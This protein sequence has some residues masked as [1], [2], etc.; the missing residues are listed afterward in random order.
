MEFSPD[1][2]SLVSVSADGTGR[3]WPVGRII[4]EAKDRIT[5][6]GWWKTDLEFSPDGRRLVACTRPHMAPVGGTAAT[7]MN[8]WEVSTG[9]S[10]TV[11]ERGTYGR[12]DLATVPGTD[13]LLCGGPESLAVK[14]KRTGE[15]IRLLDNDPTHEYQH[16]AVSPDGK[17]AAGCGRLLERSRP[18]E[19]FTVKRTGKWFLAVFNL[20]DLDKAKFFPLPADIDTWAINSLVFSLDGQFLVTGGGDGSALYR[21][22]IFEMIDGKFEQ[23]E[24]RELPWVRNG[25]VQDVAFSAD[26]RLVGV[27]AQ[28][29]YGQIWSLR[30]PKTAATFYRK[31]GLWA[32][33]FSPDGRILALGDS[34]GLQLCDLESQ[35]PLATIPIGSGGVNSLRFSPDGRTL[36]WG[37]FD[38][39]V[40]FLRTMPLK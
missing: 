29:G 31:N 8:E 24:K 35:F 20:E 19:Y 9:I 38:G 30:G 40:E 14:S 34:T 23:V 17:W 2:L 32:L 3:L 22:D 26:N 12:C 18:T 39:R 10:K 1:G 28:N 5:S 15:L 11:V 4:Q 36:A 27:A 7:F 25:E 33:A 13:Y 6:S 37:S 21:V 16:V